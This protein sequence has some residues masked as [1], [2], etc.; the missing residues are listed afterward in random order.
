MII[1]TYEYNTNLHWS[2]GQPVCMREGRWDREGL[3]VPTAV[4]HKTPS[5]DDAALYIEMS[6]KQFESMVSVFRETP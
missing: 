6:D 1:R 4:V 5:P 2:H 3:A